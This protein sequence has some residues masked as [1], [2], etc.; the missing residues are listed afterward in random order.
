LVRSWDPQK[1]HKQ[2]LSL[3]LSQFRPSKTH[4]EKENKKK[5]SLFFSTTT[6]YN[7][8]N[9]LKREM[10]KETERSSGG[11]KRN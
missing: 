10:R 11:K 5:S 7:S 2:N 3:S 4:S 8:L 6:E 9:S 1:K